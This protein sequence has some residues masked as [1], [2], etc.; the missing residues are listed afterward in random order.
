MEKYV[1]QLLG[2]LESAKGNRPPKP[3]VR[4]LYPDHPALDYGLDY[5]AEWECSPQIPM[6]ELF[7]LDAEIFPD[8]SRLNT[9]QIEQLVEAILDLWAFYNFGTYIPDG[10]P[11]DLVYKA[12]IDKWKNDPISYVS[13]GTVT[14]EFCGYEPDLCPWGMEHCTCKEFDDD[15]DMDKYKMTPEQEAEWQ[16]GVQPNGSW[17]NPKLL[18][19]NGN[20]DPSKLDDFM[21]E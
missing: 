9:T 21:N 19:E 7:G 4:V 5:I 15:F 1:N 16:K 3:N 14:L 13:E 18:D 20:F 17:V 6:N 8:A 2:D 11:M 12:L 10:T